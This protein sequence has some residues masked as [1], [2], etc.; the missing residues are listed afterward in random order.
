MLHTK[1][2][3][4][5]KHADYTFFYVRYADVKE[6]DEGATV[7]LQCVTGRRK[8]FREMVCCLFAF[9]SFALFLLIAVFAG[10][11]RAADARLPLPRVA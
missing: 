10:S 7:V 1:G 2:V 5:S 6:G 4:V 3:Y 9:A 8:H 11:R